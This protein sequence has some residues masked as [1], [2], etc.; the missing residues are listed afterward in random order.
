MYRVAHDAVWIVLVAVTDVGVAPAQI[1]P[2]AE[3]DGVVV[4]LFPDVRWELGAEG[5]ADHSLH[6]RPIELDVVVADDENHTVP[7][8]DELT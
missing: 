6:R 1:E 3:H 7:A 8:R 4:L 2:I 5:I